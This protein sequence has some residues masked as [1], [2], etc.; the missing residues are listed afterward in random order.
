MLNGNDNQSLTKYVTNKKQTV[1]NVEYAPVVNI[2]DDSRQSKETFRKML[3][4]HAEEF[5]DMLEEI[6]KDKDD[7]DYDYDPCV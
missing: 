7:F 6:M 2:S 1:I 5:A 3:K 4:E